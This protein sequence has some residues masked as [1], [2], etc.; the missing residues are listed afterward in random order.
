[1]IAQRGYGVGDEKMEAKQAKSRSL[2]PTAPVAP[3]ATSRKKMNFK[4]KYAL[5]T[6][7]K[8]MDELRAMSAKLQNELGTRDL[9]TRD[10]ARFAKLTDAL[11]KAQTELAASEEEWLELEMLRE[12]MGA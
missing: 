4:Q 11:G 9:Y 5:E 7:P 1:M 12:E 6:L 8:R 10:P 2:A 3:A